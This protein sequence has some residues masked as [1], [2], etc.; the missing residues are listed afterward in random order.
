MISPNLTQAAARVKEIE[1]MLDRL[2][3][4]PTTAQGPA[5]GGGFADL[6]A[7]QLAGQQRGTNSLPSFGLP[8]SAPGSFATATAPQDIRELAQAAA[9]RYG[10]DPS[11]VLS[12]INAESGF[13]PRS[14]SSAGA[15]GLMQLM[16][17]TARE[18]G[19]SNAFDPAQNIDG[20]VRYLKQMLQRFH[21]DVTRAVAAYNAGPAAVEQHGGVPP[22]SETRQYVERVLQG[23]SNYQRPTTAAPRTTRAARLNPAAS[24]SLPPVTLPPLP[25]DGLV[26]RAVVPS[27]PAAPVEPATPPAVAAPG[28]PLAAPVPPSGVTAP[29]PPT[30]PVA[31]AAPGLVESALA[32]PPVADG[33]EPRDEFAAPTPAANRA[34]AGHAAPPAHTRPTAQAQPVAAAPLPTSFTAES[35]AALESF[36]T[37]MSS[38]L[39]EPTPA[40]TPTTN[41]EPVHPVAAPA[42]PSVER[43]APTTTAS[44]A[45]AALRAAGVTA[46]AAVESQGVVLR[47]DAPGQG[48]QRDS[49]RQQQDPESAPRS[50]AVAAAGAPTFDLARATAAAP[51]HPMSPLAETPVQ[52]KDPHELGEMIVSRAKVLRGAGRDEFTARLELPSQGEVSV[53]VVREA[54]T[55]SVLLQTSHDGLRRD[56]EAHLPQLREALADQGLALGRA[57]VDVGG[58][59]PQH[60]QAY[61]QPGE[62]STARPWHGERGTERAEAVST[63]SPTPRA[64]RLVERPE[65]MTFWA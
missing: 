4:A 44:R 40:P 60:G 32:L 25:L 16:P 47:N 24:A 19:V 49:Q 58:G 41:P 22:F 27:G 43:A 38:L 8:G 33:D 61:P 13:D 2:S 56:L 17:G 42:A 50:E 53:R 29:T 9:A 51:G 54:N 28:T 12:V 55:V 11:L 3:E 34:G 65:G 21:G 1:G 36:T 18:L 45:G 35:S 26:Q 46:A 31:P 39:T 20:G 57:G 14:V 6:L 59:Q 37:A 15:M 52:V 23:A 10:V 5:G 48:G 7:A 64:S 62:R 30:A 63:D